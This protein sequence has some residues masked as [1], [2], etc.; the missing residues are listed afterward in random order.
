MDNDEE[1]DDDEDADDD[2]DEDGEDDD[3]EDDEV[4]HTPPAHTL[5]VRCHIALVPF[6][7]CSQVIHLVGSICRAAC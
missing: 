3:D 7:F 1:E 4:R 2:D 5:R 6:P